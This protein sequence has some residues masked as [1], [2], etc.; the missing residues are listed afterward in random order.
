[1]FFTYRQNNSGGFFVQNDDL[2]IYVV[3]EAATV[4]AAN[5]QAAA[6]GMFD[7]PFCECC[8]P[9]FYRADAGD[10]TTVPSSYGRPLNDDERRRAV[11][12]L[13]SGL[14]ARYHH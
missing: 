8:G 5:G 10:G 3:I 12:H 13:A 4:D 1:M 2:D 6:L 7:L 14:V 9:R 11:I